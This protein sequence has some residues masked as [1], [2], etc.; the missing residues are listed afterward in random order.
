MKNS[1]VH[2][3][4]SN[5]GNVGISGIMACYI[6]RVTLPILR[7]WEQG[8]YTGI[9]GWGRWGL[10]LVL[11]SIWMNV[12]D[13]WEMSDERTHWKHGRE[14]QVLLSDHRNVPKWTF[15][16]EHTEFRF[17]EEPGSVQQWTLLK[18]RNQMLLKWK[19]SPQPPSLLTVSVII[20][21]L[22]V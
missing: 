8:G 18:S 9:W 10:P 1:W 15:Q 14:I 7:Q 21:R 13:L 22:W 16:S 20:W 6:H 5:G 4:N 17:Q 3:I 12:K 2:A 11:D 19:L